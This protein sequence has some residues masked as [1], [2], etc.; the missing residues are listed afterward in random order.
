MKLK[1]GELKVFY[2]VPDKIRVEL[3]ERLT[4]L[5]KEFGYNRWASGY[6]YGT[7]VRD[8]AFDYTSEDK[9]EENNNDN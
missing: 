9:Q 8:L 7:G 6:E 3:D 5:L 1:D 4:A 2:N